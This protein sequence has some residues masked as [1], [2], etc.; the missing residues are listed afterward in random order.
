MDAKGSAIEG[1]AA[2][3]TAG[4]TIVAKGLWGRWF[5]TKDP[6]GKFIQEARK[7]GRFINAVEQQ[8]SN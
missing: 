3:A 1:G 4:L 8:A 5:S 7:Q 2:V 6:C